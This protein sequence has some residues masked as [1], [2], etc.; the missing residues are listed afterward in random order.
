MVRTKGRTKGTEYFVDPDLLRKLDFKGL[1]TL[2]GI[3]THWLKEL[4]LRDLEIYGRSGLSEIHGRIGSE[5][6]RRKVQHI[7]WGL[8]DEGEVVMQGKTRGAVYLLHKDRSN[9]GKSEQY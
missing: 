8:V 2:K 4:I 5:I 6:P 9:T 7:L 3:E 1:T